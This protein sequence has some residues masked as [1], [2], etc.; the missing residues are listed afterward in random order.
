MAMK[1]EKADAFK[2]KHSVKQKVMHIRECIVFLLCLLARSFSDLFMML[3]Q[4]HTVN[5]W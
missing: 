2:R 5:S 1:R 3:N 4:Q